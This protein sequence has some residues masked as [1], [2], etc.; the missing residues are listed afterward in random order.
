MGVNSLSKPPSNDPSDDDMAAVDVAVSG[1][2]TVSVSVMGRRG[3]IPPDA[4]VELLCVDE[5]P[6]DPLP[7]TS[8][9]AEVGAP[10]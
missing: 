5:E 4:G 10:G 7:Y 2:A 6:A 8:A 9:A 3:C 1:T